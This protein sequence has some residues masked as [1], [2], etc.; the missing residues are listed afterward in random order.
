MSFCK[1]EYNVIPKGA[2]TFKPKYLD[3]NSTERLLLVAGRNILTVL[4]LHGDKFTLH[5]DLITKDHESFNCCDAKWSPFSDSTIAT[6]EKCNV[7]VWNL[8]IPQKNKLQTEFRAAEQ[9]G[10]NKICFSHYQKNILLTGSHDSK[11]R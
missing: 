7:L 9:R 10:L 5:S 1:R 6:A 8:N 3:Y 2:F 11:I 4:H